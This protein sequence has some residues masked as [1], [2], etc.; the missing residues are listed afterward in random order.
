MLGVLSGGFASQSVVVK[1]E[2]KVSKK[3]FIYLIYSHYGITSTPK[4]HE[5]FI[6]Y[7]MLHW[8]QNGFRQAEILRMLSYLKHFLASLGSS[9]AVLRPFGGRVAE[10]FFT[11]TLP[12]T[13]NIYPISLLLIRLYY[14][15]STLID[16]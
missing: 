12:S 8:R 5:Y 10:K 15:C 14:C 16:S 11:Y 13:I 7:Q 1:R 3:L 6:L 9:Q 2:P 4:L